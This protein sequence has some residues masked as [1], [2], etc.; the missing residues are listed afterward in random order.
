MEAEGQQIQMN[1]GTVCTEEQMNSRYKRTVGTEEQ[2]VRRDSGNRGFRGT[3]RMEE[4]WLQGNSQYRGT[5][6]RWEQRTENSDN[7]ATK[8]Q[9]N[10]RKKW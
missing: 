1:R 9:R 2:Q 7:G 5:E 8:E 10:Y 6:K 4:Q 3:V